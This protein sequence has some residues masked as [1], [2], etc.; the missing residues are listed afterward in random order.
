[1]HVD[2]EIEASGAKLPPEPQIFVP[3]AP[4]AWTGCDEDVVEMWVVL[5]NG[6]SLRLDEIRNR[7]LRK[8][9]AQRPNRGRREHHVAYQ[10]WPDQ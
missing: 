3:A 5:Q 7:G 10:P 9:P 1:M 6:G 4:A 8:T 2:H